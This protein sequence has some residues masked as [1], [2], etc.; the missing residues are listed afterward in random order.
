MLSSSLSVSQPSPPTIIGYL[1][2]P[3]KMVMTLVHIIQH[4]YNMLT[5]RKMIWNFVSLAVSTGDS[6]CDQ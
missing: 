2:N 1:S 5:L 6:F 4:P 3:E